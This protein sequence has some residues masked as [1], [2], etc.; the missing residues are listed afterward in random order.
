MSA[1]VDHCGIRFLP[2]RSAAV[3]PARGERAGSHRGG[4]R[5]READDADLLDER[6]AHGQP[7]LRSIAGASTD[8]GGEAVP[9]VLVGD[10]FR[11][12]AWIGAKPPI[13][14]SCATAAS[15]AP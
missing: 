4:E 10:L 14:A 12:D 8:S 2:R 9:R 11:L 1:G 15:Q 7:P 6:A 3:A 13:C 5:G